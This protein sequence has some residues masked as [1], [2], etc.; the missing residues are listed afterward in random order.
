MWPMSDNEQ[1]FLNAV[2][3]MGSAK[4]VKIKELLFPLMN[5]EGPQHMSHLPEL[6][7]KISLLY[8]N[9]SA[10][11]PIVPGYIQIT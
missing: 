11:S 1:I 3:Q 4:L 9:S 5:Q 10:K 7:G 2:L 6:C 8:K